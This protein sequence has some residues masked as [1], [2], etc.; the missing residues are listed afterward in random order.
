MGTSF[1]I[2]LSVVA[3]IGLAI[4]KQ[5]TCVPHDS[6]RADCPCD[7]GWAGQCVLIVIAAL[8]GMAASF[9][10]SGHNLIGGAATMAALLLVLEIPVLIARLHH[11]HDLHGHHDIH[12]QHR[13]A[14]AH[15]QPR[16][17]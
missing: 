8:A 13:P 10:F 4:A 15:R 3:V 9:E 2:F 11:H 1:L 6:S 16:R 12:R 17:R 14:P 7:C 5:I